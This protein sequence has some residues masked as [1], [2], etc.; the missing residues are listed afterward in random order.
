[1]FTKARHL[2]SSF[3]STPSE[4]V[5]FQKFSIALR[6]IALWLPVLLALTMGCCSHLILTI[7]ARRGDRM[8]A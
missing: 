2:A 7:A 3:P 6:N 4:S 1:V 5:K 8:E